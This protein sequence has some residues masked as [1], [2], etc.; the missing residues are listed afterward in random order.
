MRCFFLIIVKH[1]NTSLRFT[2]HSPM[3]GL[4]ISVGLVDV[5]LLVVVV[6]VVVEH[7]CLTRKSSIEI[8]LLCPMF[9]PTT[10]ICRFFDKVRLKLFGIQSQL[11]WPLYYIM[12]HVLRLY[13]FTNLQPT[14][15]SIRWSF[16][17]M[18]V[19]YW[20]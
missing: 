16:Q 15:N 11:Y 1:V 6:V 7:T 12:Y 8:P 18:K 5:A 19:I 17:P 14:L 3:P 13:Q 20:Y 9:E 2:F 10:S 4:W